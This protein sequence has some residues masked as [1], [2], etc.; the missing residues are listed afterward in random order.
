[1]KLKIKQTKKIRGEIT[2]SGSKNATLPILAVSILTNEKIK[3]KVIG[4]GQVVISQIPA[5]GIDISKERSTI[6]IY[7]TN[8]RKETVTVPNFIGMTVHDADLLG[9]NLGLN[10]KIRGINDNSMN[11]KLTITKQSLLV[12]D[13]VLQ[14]TVIELTVLK[15]D[16]E[17]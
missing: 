9:T 1:M 15:T 14:G 3:Y 8:K 16:F 4:D 5:S 10:I 12:G 6:Y 13:S 11:Y 7:T 2:V 17:D